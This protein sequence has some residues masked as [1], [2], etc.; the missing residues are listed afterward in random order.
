M[1]LPF[2]VIVALWGLLAIIWGTHA[3]Y[4]SRPTVARQSTRSRLPQ[5]SLLLCGFAFIS[6]RTLGIAWLDRV[7]IPAG[8][9]TAWT[10]VWIVLIGVVLA[11]WARTILGGNWSGTATLKAGHTLVRSGPYRIVR[12]PIY[13]GILVGVLGTAIANGTLHAL[14]A[15]PLCALSY[16]MK[17]QSEEDLLVGQFGQDY[18]QYRARVKALIPYLL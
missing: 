7:V 15:V 8:A 12:H 5:S 14:I 18:L 13:T 9:Q 4:D 10:G 16:W 3:L 6:K 2:Q 11:V 1:T 17:I